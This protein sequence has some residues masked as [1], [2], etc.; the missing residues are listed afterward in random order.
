MDIKALFESK[1]GVLKTSELRQNGVYHKQLASLIEEGA[2]IKIKPGYYI[3]NGEISDIAILNTLYPDGVFCLE[4]ALYYNGLIKIKP[5]TYHIAFDKDC[6]K[7]RFNLDCIMVKP[8]FL[9]PENLKIG[10]E[11]KIIEGINIKVYD[12]E[13]CIC[14]VL[15]YRNKISGEL[16][17]DAMRNYIS[18]E[19]KNLLK[20]N[21][22]TER[23]RISATA[24]ELL[25]VWI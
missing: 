17:S 24:R 23:L 5:N 11:E 6:T 14:D 25:G 7:S 22:Y 3:Q 9:E 16:F 20:L 13:R 12:C 19:D 15:R 21:D 1:N 18:K 2:I 4:S 8:Y 10:T